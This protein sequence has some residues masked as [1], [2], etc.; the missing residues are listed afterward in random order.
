MPELCEWRPKDLAPIFNWWYN[1]DL[2]NLHRE[3]PQT[4][5]F[6]FLTLAQACRAIVWV[7]RNGR[8]VM[9]GGECCNKDGL[10]TVFKTREN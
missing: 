7:R 2:A 10:L 8:L 6:L 4:E 1:D 9:Y 5:L 3:N